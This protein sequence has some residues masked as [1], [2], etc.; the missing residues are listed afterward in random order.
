VQ[1][2][3]TV[4]VPFE[5]G[6]IDVFS[7]TNGG[8]SWG[9]SQAIATIDFHT[10]AAG[11]RNLDLPSATIDGGGNVFVAWS[12]CRFRKNCAEN[13]IVVSSSADGKTWSPVARIPIDATTSTVD[14]FLPG[15]GADPATSGANAHLTIV[16]YYYPNTNCT[17]STCQ[18][19]AGFTTSVDGGTTW[20]RGAELGGP[21]KVGWLPVSDLGPMLADYIAVTYVNGNPYGVLA[22]A[23]PPTGS[24][25]N[26]AIYTTRNPLPV[27][28]DAPRF[29]SINDLPVPNAHSDHP[30]KFFYD[31]E[32][33]REIPRSR[34]ITNTEAK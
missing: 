33:H 28:Y 11:I 8:A 25:L 30:M 9:R 20:T 5:G 24:T 18:L 23:L 16:Y 13:D 21:M 2:N 3:G 34:W 29:S 31:D 4:I 10:D 14:H 26:E 7:S 6:G 19:Y 27:S 1:P 22:G 15:I 17:L 32:G 12:D